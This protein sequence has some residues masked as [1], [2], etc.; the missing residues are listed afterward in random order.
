VSSKAHALPAELNYFTSTPKSTLQTE[1][2]ISFSSDLACHLVIMLL[3]FLGLLFL[4]FR[5]YCKHTDYKF[6]LYLYIGRADRHC[7]SWV[8]S[9]PLYPSLYTFSATKYIDDLSVTG[10]IIPHLCVNWQ[11]LQ[12]CSQ[13]TNETYNLPKIIS[14]TWRQKL[15][16]NWILA[17]PFWCLLF[18]E[19]CCFGFALQKLG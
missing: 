1:T 12:I 8:R 13:A 19:Y 2:Y 18:T 7:K 17:K 9:F 10:C 16:L 4:I 6:D 14:L 11:T 3:V 15:R 5:W